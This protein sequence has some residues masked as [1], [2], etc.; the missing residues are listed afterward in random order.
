MSNRFIDTVD[1]DSLR[2]KVSRKLAI[3]RNIQQSDLP[4]YQNRDAPGFD[5]PIVEVADEDRFRFPSA[6]SLTAA[7]S[8]RVLRDLYDVSGLEKG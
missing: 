6:S 2:D 3:S 7:S 4:R 5:E 8:E 1:L